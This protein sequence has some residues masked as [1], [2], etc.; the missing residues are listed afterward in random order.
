MAGHMDEVVNL[1]D[2]ARRG[3]ER[4]GF[5]LS[6]VL[7]P[8][9]VVPMLQM[10]INTYRPD[11][12]AVTLHDMQKRIQNTSNVYLSG[13]LC[14]PVPNLALPNLVLDGRIVPAQHF[15]AALA[16]GQPSDALPPGQ[17]FLAKD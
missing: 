13:V 12:Q 4:H 17:Y 9:P 5:L 8:E 10:Y 2:E 15:V 7:L 6:A 1:I 3:A 11:G 14:I 16:M